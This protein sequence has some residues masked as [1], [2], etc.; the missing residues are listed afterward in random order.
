M[1]LFASKIINDNIKWNGIKCPI[2]WISIVNVTKN[3]LLSTQLSPF[4]EYCVWAVLYPLYVT[5]RW[6]EWKTARKTQAY[7]EKSVH[8]KKEMKWNEP[9]LTEWQTHF[10]FIVLVQLRPS[11]TERGIWIEKYTKLCLHAN[12]CMGCTLRSDTLGLG[13]STL[14]SICFSKWVRVCLC[15]FGIRQSDI[16]S[17]W[18]QELNRED[19]HQ[20]GPNFTVWHISIE[21]CAHF[22]CFPMSPA[23]LQFLFKGIHLNSSDGSKSNSLHSVVYQMNWIVAMDTFQ[24]CTTCVFS[25]IAVTIRSN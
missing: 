1:H 11:S 3:K 17:K 18:K 22:P 25:F 15:L 6:W 24:M 16:K 19:S 7:S 23:Y 4:S 8:H 10:Q 14:P 21:M 2:S 5:Q 13:L 20:P 9:K 12:T